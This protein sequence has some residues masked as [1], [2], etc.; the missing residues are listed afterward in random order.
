M[1][2][3]DSA[4]SGQSN[5][6]TSSAKQ[7]LIVFKSA[8]VVHQQSD[9]SKKAV[10]GATAATTANP[11][12]VDIDLPM[13]DDEEEE[14]EDGEAKEAK[15]IEDVDEESNARKSPISSATQSCHLTLLI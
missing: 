6:T 2:A 15:I 3:M 4:I 8:G 14:H 1:Q 11:E 13:D 5:G 10:D 12:E 9:A 7:P